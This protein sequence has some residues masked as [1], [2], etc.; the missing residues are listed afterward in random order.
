MVCTTI[1]GICWYLIYFGNRTCIKYK[2]NYISYTIYTSV[3][4]LTLTSCYKQFIKNNE[5]KKNI[6]TDLLWIHLQWMFILVLYLQNY[7]RV[8]GVSIFLE[9]HWAVWH[10]SS[11]VLCEQQQY[12]CWNHKQTAWQWWEKVIF[13][14]CNIIKQNNKISIW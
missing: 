4:L 7:P 3:C 8:V 6:L 14:F 5:Q 11:E 10:I 2:P 1:I 12:K 13:L 9:Y